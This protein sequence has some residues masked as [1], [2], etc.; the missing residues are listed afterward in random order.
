VNWG[1]VEAPPTEALTQSAPSNTAL[2]LVGPPSL[3]G[4]ERQISVAAGRRANPC[5]QRVS[6]GSFRTPRKRSHSDLKPQTPPWAGTKCPQSSLW[7]NQRISSSSSRKTV[8]TTAFRAKS[9]VSASEAIHGCRTIAEHKLV[10]GGAFLGLAAYSYFSG[11]SQLEKQKAKILASK[12]MFGMRSRRLG[13]TG[14]SLG[15]AWLGL[16]RMVK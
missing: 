11:Q 6:A 9:W 4:G 13:I 10:G 5:T 7:T 14:I 3:G 16:W 1:V 15:L 12:S 8:G 2:Q